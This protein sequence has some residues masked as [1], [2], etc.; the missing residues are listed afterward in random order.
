[1]EKHTAS[2]KDVPPPS[3]DTHKYNICPTP[4]KERQTRHVVNYGA[5]APPPPRNTTL[6]K[7]SRVDNTD[8]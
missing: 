3:T 4:A 6:S 1:M 2:E 5:S 7:L 8:S